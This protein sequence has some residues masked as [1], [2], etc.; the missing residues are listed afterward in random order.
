MEA[1]SLQE[2]GEEG[3]GA[4]RHKKNFC[5]IVQHFAL[6]KAHRGRNHYRRVRELEVQVMGS[7]MFA[8]LY[9]FK[10]FSFRDPLAYV[11]ELMM[12]HPEILITA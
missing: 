11:T 6:E 10:I 8:P 7:G 9:P 4:E 5:K 2:E 1:G 12:R 3:A